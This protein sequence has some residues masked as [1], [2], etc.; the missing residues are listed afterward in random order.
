M[1]VKT[2]SILNKNLTA[3]LEG[4]QQSGT[5]KT[6]RPIAT[7]MDTVVAM[8]GR[9]HVLVLSSN[10]YL[11]LAD[12]P[13]VVAAGIEALKKYGAGTASV[14]FICGTFTIHNE[15]EAALARL[16]QSEAALTYVSCW[17]TNIPTWGIWKAS[18]K[19]LTAAAGFSLSPTA[20]S[21]WKA[22]SPNCPTYWRWHS[23][24]RH[25]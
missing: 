14:R 11:G 12:H 16:H 5:L 4:M 7:P 13:E 25:R 10:N 8:Q 22:T 2:F 19:K 15:I 3:E 9:E 1:E 21:A 6:F 17:F 24:T 23:V 18:S 20:C